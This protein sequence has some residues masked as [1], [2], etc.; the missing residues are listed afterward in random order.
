[1]FSPRRRA[2][3]RFE[4]SPIALTVME[5]TFSCGALEIL[6]AFPSGVP[7]IGKYTVTNCPE[8]KEGIPPLESV[9]ERVTTPEASSL[10]STTIYVS[11]SSFFPRMLFFIIT[12]RFPKRE[13]SQNG[14]VI[15]S[16]R[17]PAEP[18]DNRL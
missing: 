2:Q 18:L 15:L 7:V 11:L 1:M 17:Q 13:M 9:S 10:R 4:N 14:A 5:R 16:L 8:M 12:N 6:Y 3:R